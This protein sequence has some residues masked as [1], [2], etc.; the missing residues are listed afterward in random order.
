MID[1]HWT[2]DPDCATFWESVKRLF[3]EGEISAALYPQHN[4]DKVYG[5]WH[6]AAMVDMMADRVRTEVATQQLDLPACIPSR[7]FKKT[8]AQYFRWKSTTW[9]NKV[10]YYENAQE[11][12]YGDVTPDWPGEINERTLGTLDP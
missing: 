10:K 1:I 9:A 12:A 4:E 2:T 3:T 6:S 8:F 7:H 11:V 5:L